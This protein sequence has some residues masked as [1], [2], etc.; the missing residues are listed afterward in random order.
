MKIGRK[1]RSRSDCGLG[2]NQRCNLR[3]NFQLLLVLLLS[4]S[5]S[6]V[7]IGCFQSY[8]R[9]LTRRNP[10]HHLNQRMTLVKL[11]TTQASVGRCYVSRGHKNKDEGLAVNVRLLA[12]GMHC[13][14]FQ[15]LKHGQ[16]L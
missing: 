16:P 2:A 15:M 14:K 8:G 4:D 12:K 6:T 7:S 5:K 11:K 3:D 1:Y 10:S 13:H 9:T